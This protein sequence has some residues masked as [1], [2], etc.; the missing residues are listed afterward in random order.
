MVLTS[1]ANLGPYVILGRLGAGGMGE[2]FHARDTRLGREVAIK[3]LLDG[4]ES[5]GDSH[6]RFLGEARAASALN[7]PNI[8]CI[9]DVGTQDGAP[10]IV[11]ELVAGESLRVQIRRGV[12]DID[13]ALAVAMQTAE[14]LQCAHEAG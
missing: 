14:G 9:Y 7:H 8:V 2:V 4:R 6:E 5:R 11:M 13:R 1:G 12:F 3:V 10:Y